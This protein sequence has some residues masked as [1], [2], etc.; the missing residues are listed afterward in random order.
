MQKFS[1]PAF[2][3]L[4]FL[5]G[6]AI[7]H[8]APDP[9]E[10]SREQALAKSQGAIG[11]TLAGV[12]LTAPGGRQVAVEDFRGKP[13][14]ISLIF[15]SCHHICPSTTV[16]LQQ[17]VQKARS[18]LDAD[19]FQVI[20]V[21]FDTANDTPERMAEFG[22]VNG[23]TDPRWQFLAG[24]AATIDS[25][26][27]QLGFIYSPTSGGFDHLIQSSI[28]DADGKVYRQVYG[29][30]F[31]TPQLID[32][33]KELVFGEPREQSSLSYLGNRIR[34]FCTV[35]DPATDSYSIDISVFIGT[36]VGIISSLVLGWVLVKEWRKSIR[37]GR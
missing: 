26:V 20:T 3:G 33:L 13:L 32:P 34:L 4:C 15:T 31:P 23:V 7:A 22:R 25:L 9:V 17:V 8:A 10:F 36:F 28:I 16:Y 30:T 11:K 27:K 21:G 19:A 12:T 24:D 14:V 35:Y 37:A 1:W 18:A 5:V 29:I 2:A 6:A